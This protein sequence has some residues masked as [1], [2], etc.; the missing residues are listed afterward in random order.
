MPTDFLIKHPE[1]SYLYKLI[2]K[3]YYLPVSSEFTWCLENT[4]FSHLWDNPTKKKW[5]HPKSEMHKEFVEQ[6][7][8]PW[9]QKKRYLSTQN[10]VQLPQSEEAWLKWFHSPRSFKLGVITLPI[11]PL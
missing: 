1:I 4:K 10:S 5:V 6:I 9:L 7:V 8:Y 3:E 11:G 2:D